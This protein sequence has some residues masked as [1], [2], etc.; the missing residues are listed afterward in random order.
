MGLVFCHDWA[1]KTAKDAATKTECACV[2]FGD[3][4]AG[5]TCKNLSL[6]AGSCLEWWNAF[7]GHKHIFGQEWFSVFNLHERICLGP[8]PKPS[9]TRIRNANQFLCNQHQVLSFKFTSAHGPGRHIYY[10]NMKLK[11]FKTFWFFY[12]FKLGLKG[13]FFPSRTENIFSYYTFVTNFLSDSSQGQQIF[14]LT[15][16]DFNTVNKKMKQIRA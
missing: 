9:S 6:L 16:S 1:L 5:I 2:C 12:Y 14:L 4:F 10:N 13:D 8:N 15:F 11:M 3:A 7:K